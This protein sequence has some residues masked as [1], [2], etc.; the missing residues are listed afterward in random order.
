MCNVWPAQDYGVVPRQEVP[1]TLLILE[2]P[3]VMYWPQN[4]KKLILLPISQPT[5]SPR[6]RSQDPRAKESLS[7][8]LLNGCT[9]EMSIAQE[10]KVN[11]PLSL[12]GQRPEVLMSLAASIATALPPRRF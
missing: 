11:V 10:Q 9:G 12:P 2:P 8:Y 1:G 3:T 7:F 6:S 4:E 5:T